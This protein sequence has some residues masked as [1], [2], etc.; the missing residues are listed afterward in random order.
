MRCLTCGVDNPLEARFCYNCGAPM[1]VPLATGDLVPRELGGLI[2]YTFEVYRSRFGAFFAIAL[3]AQVIPL[4]ST[5]LPIS[6][7]TSWPSIVLSVASIAFGV[8]AQGATA[9]AVADWRL[10]REI[11][12]GWCYRR[13]LN[14]VGPLLGSAAVVAGALALSALLAWAVVG[15]FL[16][17][18]LLVAWFFC[19]QAVMLE[20]KDT[21]QALGRSRELVRGNWLRVF[22]IGAA[23]VITLMCIG[24]LALIPVSVAAALSPIA[25]SALASLTSGAIMPV[26]YIGSTL[27]YMD[28]R[29]RREGHNLEAMASELEVRPSLY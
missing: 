19:F 11:G 22:G 8:V 27:V 24:I 29:I 15:I 5:L 21:L 1:P 3:I 10:G 14:R 7:L 4:A 25:A 28:L 12:A 17:V 16:F 20:G 26:L 9:I 23:Y 13:A 18:Y 6:D 2:E